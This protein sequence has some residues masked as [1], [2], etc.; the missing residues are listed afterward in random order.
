MGAASFE[1]LVGEPRDKVKEKQPP[2]EKKNKMP[3][4]V[5]VLVLLQPLQR[6]KDQA[7]CLKITQNV[8]SEYFILAFS[9]N[10][11]PIKTDLS[12]NTV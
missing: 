1:K 9:T 8:A 6:N 10:F 12:G 2:N 5:V 7:H 11:C 3:Q 4:A